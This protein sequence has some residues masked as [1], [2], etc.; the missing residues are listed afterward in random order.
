MRDE[1]ARQDEQFYASGACTLINGLF[2][3]KRKKKRVLILLVF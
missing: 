1:V 3:Y 2:F